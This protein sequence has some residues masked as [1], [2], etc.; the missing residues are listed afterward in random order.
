MNGGTSSQKYFFSI[1]RLYNYVKIFSF[2]RLVGSSGEKKAVNLTINTF[3]DLGFSNEQIQ[4]ETFEFSDFYS[5]TLIKLIMV[6]NLTFSLF[7]LMFVYINLFI[8]LLIGGIMAIFVVLIVKGLKHPEIPGFWGE[9]YG[10]TISATNICIKIP[11]KDLNSKEAGNI[12]ISAHLDS[13]SQSFKTYWRVF[14]YK[15]WLYSGVI[16][17]GF[18]ISLFISTYTILKI[19][20]WVLG[21]GIWIF[22]ILISTSNVFLIFLNTNNFSLGSLD[23]ASGMSIIFELSKKIKENPLKHF[24]VWI[25]QFSAEEMG[26]MGSRVFVNNHE[27]DFVKGRVFQLNLDMISC[28]KKSRNQVEYLKSYGILPRKK[29]APLLSKYL[30]KAALQELVKIKGFHLST[31]AHTDSVPFH[32]RGYDSVDIVTR[33]GAKYAHTK[34]DKPYRV[35][36]RVL[37]DACVLTW[38]VILSIDRDYEILCRN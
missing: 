20:L 6:I 26:T 9:Y 14:F 12:I 16:L 23:N 17:G 31:G 21:F 25:C 18:L 5:T 28:L 13:K 3:K 10:N 30:E 2:P 22:T 33:A 38:R 1:E 35:D 27:Q 37:I 4:K 29:V 32:Q 15:M 11:A 19:N 7:I 8:T 36:P 24:N 34:S